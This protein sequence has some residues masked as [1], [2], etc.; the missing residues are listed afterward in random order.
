MF[1]SLKHH[2]PEILSELDTFVDGASMKKTGTHP[3]VNSG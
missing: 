2:S 1:N 3:F